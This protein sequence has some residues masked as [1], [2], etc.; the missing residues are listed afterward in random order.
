MSQPAEKLDSPVTQAQADLGAIKA[1]MKATWEDGDYAGF[2]KFMEPGAVEIL[3][4]WNIAA[5]QR[6][7]DVG[8]G[9]G[10]SAIPAARRGLQVT[11][12]DIAENLIGHA[13]KRAETE[14]IEARFDVGDAEDLP[15]DEASF[16]VAISMIGAMFAPRPDRV[17]AELA[18]VLRPG[19]KLYMANWTPLS[20]P[21]QMFKCVSSVVPP[22]PGFIPP[23]LWGDE[24]TVRERLGEDFTEIALTRRVYPKWQYNFGAADVVELF[25]THFGPVKRAFE[26][27]YERGQDEFRQQLE[28]IFADNGKTESGVLTITNGEYLEVVATRG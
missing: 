10:Q 1:K 18:R 28:A 24:A 3:D 12:V 27:L 21:A 17:A 20:M 16:D 15:Y 13:R 8:C 23:V 26:T 25:R 5:G 22:P 14:G 7:L 19:G 2:A 6:L 9:S 11:G 4:A